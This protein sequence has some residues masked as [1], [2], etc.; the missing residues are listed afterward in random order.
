[1]NSKSFRL[2]LLKLLIFSIFL[3]STEFSL[4]QFL[5][6]KYSRTIFFL[7]NLLFFSITALTHFILIHQSEKNNFRNFVSYFMAATTGKLLI[8]LMVIFF[9]LFFEKENAQPFIIFFLILYVLYTV[10][11]TVSILKFFKK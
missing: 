11:E 2:F 7:L 6:E 4:S 8:Y 3:V 5:P 9:Y 10:F 1:M